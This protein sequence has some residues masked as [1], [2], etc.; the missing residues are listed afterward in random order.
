MIEIARFS[1]TAAALLVA[2]V[3]SAFAQS[4]PPPEQMLAELK[5]T[6]QH[7]VRCDFTMP[8]FPVKMSESKVP[9]VCSPLLG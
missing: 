1:T 7:P 8:A 5:T 3:A 9:V 2:L 6:V 4:P